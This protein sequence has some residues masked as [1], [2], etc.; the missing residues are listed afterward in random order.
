MKR[1]LIIEDHVDILELL[2]VLLIKNGYEVSVAH[3]GLE[4]FKKA[5]DLKPDLVLLDLMLPKMHGLEVCEKIK[6]QNKNIP[7]IILSALGE[8]DDIVKGLHMG[9]SDYVVKPFRSKELVARIELALSNSVSQ[10]A[11][12]NAVLKH[13][14]LDIDTQ[15]NLVKLE[16]Q[17]LTLTKTEYLLLCELVSSNGRIF[18]RDQLIDKVRGQDVVIVDRNI[19]VH[20]ASIRKKLGSYGKKILTVRGVGYRFMHDE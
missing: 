10:K 14:D 12:D 4:G 9:A 18:T 11:Q 19:D 17:T 3:D 6:N 2:T 20:M 15:R 7:I 8:E 5:M 1:I 13:K 16:G